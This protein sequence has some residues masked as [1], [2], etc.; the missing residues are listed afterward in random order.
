MR[1]AFVDKVRVEPS[2]GLRGTCPCCGTEVVAKCG[3]FKLHHW[4]HKS[5]EGCD[6]W[7]ENE[8]EWHRA[9]KLC[10]PEEWQEQVFPGF[11][12]GER[13]IAD[14]VAAQGVVLEFQSYSISPEEM[15]ARE[16][17]YDSMI[18]IVNGAKRD[19][20]KV[21]FGMSICDQHTKDPYLRM[22]RWVGRSKILAKWSKAS[23][24]VYLDFDGN[25]VWHLLEYDE[26]DKTGLIKAYPKAR[27]VQF[28]G[29][30][31]PPNNVTN[32]APSAPDAAKPRRL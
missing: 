20:D 21:Y 30:V 9:W 31:F 23:C 1:Y 18:W 14:V 7:W 26:K 4:A 22:I 8:S 3:D 19:F 24:H 12:P 11:D 16:R 28:F 29:G 32:Y 13:H 25:E 10:F 15:K 2:K 17:F 6:P 5:L 27:F